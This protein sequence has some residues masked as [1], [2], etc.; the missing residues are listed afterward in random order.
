[1]VSF[2]G[3]VATREAAMTAFAKSW[4]TERNWKYR[5]FREELL[6]AIALL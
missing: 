3:Y 1:M 5:T 2:A 6:I 4:R